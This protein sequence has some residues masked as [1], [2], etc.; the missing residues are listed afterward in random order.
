MDQAGITAMQTTARAMEQILKQQQQQEAR[1]R[2][3]LANA[4]GFYHNLKK[5]DKVSFFIPPTAHEAEVLGRKAKHIAHF[6][7]PAVITKQLSTTTYI[8]KYNGRSYARCLSELRPYRSEGQ[9]NLISVA[10]NVGTDLKINNFVAFSD[11]DDPNDKNFNR[12]HV[13]KII[14]IAD[15]QAHI[16]ITRRTRQT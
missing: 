4:K 8:I 12:I 5:G 10:N 9:P 7:G 6:K 15:G 2:A 1:E 16:Q 14:N 11:T 3:A 13:G